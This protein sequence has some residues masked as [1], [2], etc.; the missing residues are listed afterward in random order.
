MSTTV[1][2]PVCQVPG[3]CSPATVEVFWC[4]EYQSPP[5]SYCTPYTWCRYLC[6]EHLHIN[7]SGRVGEVEPRGIAAY[8]YVNCGAMDQGWCEYKPFDSEEWVDR[9][10]LPT[11]EVQPELMPPPIVELKRFTWSKE[12]FMEHMLEQAQ[13]YRGVA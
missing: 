2:T 4:D 9:D 3:C 13:R 10:L 12:W 8:P 1:Q 5:I 11:V 6:E 7:E